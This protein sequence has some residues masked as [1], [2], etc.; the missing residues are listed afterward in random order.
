MYIFFF[1]SFFWGVTGAATLE[2][3]AERP[4][5]VC[6]NRLKKKKNNCEEMKIKKN[7]NIN[8]VF[9]LTLFVFWV[10]FDAGA[11][12]RTQGAHRGA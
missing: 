3:D 7:E 11:A 10:E 4:Q 6:A 1:P 12:R 8:N 9:K 5:Y 2:E